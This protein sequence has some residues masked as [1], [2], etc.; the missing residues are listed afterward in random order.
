MTDKTF[1]VLIDTDN[2]SSRQI[3]KVLSAMTDRGVAMIRRAYGD[4][5]KKSPA[6]KDALLAHAIVPVQQYAY[7]IGKN[8]TDFALVIDAMDI[9]HRNLVDGFAIVSS[10]SDFT[11]LAL[12][13]REE[14]KEVVG[15]GERQ[16]PAPFRESCGTF[17]ELEPLPPLEP[18]DPEPSPPA[19]TVPPPSMDV[20][21]SPPA[22]PASPQKPS[23]SIT[24]RRTIA[25]AI[26]D[27]SLRNGR[28]LLTCLGSELKKRMPGFTPKAYGFSQLSRLLLSC[29]E[30][31]VLENS[32]TTIVAVRP[33]KP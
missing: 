4:W 31:V 32:T 21:P 2:I 11:P 3:D 30:F 25:S 17:V 23:V 22:S 28:C 13:L 7:T 9:L 10:D 18:P 14:G 12:R 26:N 5:S 1:A 20:P 29:E 15:I 6:W 16:T 27:L 24:V 19:E 33:I 8:A